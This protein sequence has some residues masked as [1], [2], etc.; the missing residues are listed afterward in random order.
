MSQH[1]VMCLIYK[2]FMEVN[3][4]TKIQELLG[5]YSE[6]FPKSEFDVGYTTK[7]THRIKLMDNTQIKQPYRWIPV[8]RE[9]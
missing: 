8:D 4:K 1:Q 3:E 7:V 6:V 9:K 5:K 2:W